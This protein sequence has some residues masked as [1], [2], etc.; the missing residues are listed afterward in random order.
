MMEESSGCEEDNVGKKRRQNPQNYK[1]NQIK[2][3]RLSGQAYE[4]FSGK[5]VEEKKVGNPCR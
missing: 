5:K 2:S 3:A 4:S 1:R